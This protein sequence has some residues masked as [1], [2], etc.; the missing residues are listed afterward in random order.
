MKDMNSSSILYKD[1]L[2]L[3]ANKPSGIPVHETKDPN[4]KDFTRE[5][6]EFLQLDYLRTANRLDL[7]TTGIVVFGLDPDQNIWIDRILQSSVK[8][9]LVIVSGEILEDEFR[10]ESF[11]KDGNKRVSTVRSGGKK[12]I[13]KFRKLYF[14]LKR[15][16]TLVEAELVTGRRHQIRIHLSELGFPILGDPVYGNSA[17]IL[18]KTNVKNEQLYLHSWKLIL[19]HEPYE[20]LVIQV[21]PPWKQDYLENILDSR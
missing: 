6:Q 10:V 9:Y 17:K 8:Y 15:N 4:R 7:L 20:N 21:K 13:T 14:D 11:L 12:A 3:I 2:I 1:D 19:G 18:N 5:I 16:E